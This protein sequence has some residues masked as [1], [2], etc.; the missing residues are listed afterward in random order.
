MPTH[1]QTAATEQES[2][3]RSFNRWF[4]AQRAHESYVN[5]YRGQMVEGYYFV[6]LERLER[7]LDEAAEK[8][9]SSLRQPVQYRVGA[10][11]PGV[12]T[13]DAL[14]A[15]RDRARHLA[16]HLFLMVDQKA[17]RDSGGDDGQGHY[18]GDYHAERIGEEIRS[19]EK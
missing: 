10:F 13:L 14:V 15:E 12:T 19:W 3:G 18:E 1:K 11:H 9:D 4:K 7:E 8:L 2:W 6:Q 17:W 5:R 16:K